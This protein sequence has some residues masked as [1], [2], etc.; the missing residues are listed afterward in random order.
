M[1]VVRVRFVFFDQEY[2]YQAGG[3]EQDAC[4]DHPLIRSRRVLGNIQPAFKQSGHLPGCQVADGGGNGMQANIQA[5]DHGL[6]FFFA[7][8]HH[9]GR[10]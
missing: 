5:K 2:R 7:E 4:S 10:M 6:V 8:S 3:G 9:E 1:L